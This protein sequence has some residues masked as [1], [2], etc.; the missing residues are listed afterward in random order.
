MSSRPH[1]QGSVPRSVTDEHRAAVLRAMNRPRFRWWMA[2]EY[3]KHILIAI[4]LFLLLRTFI[5]EAFKIPT[6]SMKN[7]LMVGDFLLVNKFVYGAEIPYTNRHLPAFRKPE[8][9][10]IIVFKYPRDQTKN[11]VKRLIGLPGDTLQMRDG[12]M[13]VNGV[14]LNEPYVVHTDPFADPSPEEFSWQRS[15][16]VRSAEASDAY[17]PSRNNWGPLVVPEKNYFMLGDNRDDS[18][19]SRYWGFVPESLVMG[20]PMMVYYS[21]KM[22]APDQHPWISDVRWGRI[23][24]R[25]H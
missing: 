14:V 5:V 24:T 7:T 23:G 17:H 8:R 21:Y 25:V 22:D 2:G 9:F 19:D 3:A 1:P 4:P 16:L 15:F 20:E 10:D 11:Y 13:I 6:G 18:S 12:R